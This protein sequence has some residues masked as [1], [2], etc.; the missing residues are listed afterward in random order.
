MKTSEEKRELIWTELRKCLELEA[1]HNIMMQIIEYGTSRAN[2]AITDYIDI[3]SQ[4][5][6]RREVNV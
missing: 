6:A 1:A 5:Y 3:F 4:S 2:D